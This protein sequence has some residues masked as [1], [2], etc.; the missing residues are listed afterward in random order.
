[1][2]ILYQNKKNYNTLTVPCE[3]SKTVSFASSQIKYVVVCSPPF[4]FEV[5][6]IYCIAFGSAS[7]TCCLPKSIAIIL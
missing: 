7:S 3:K 6:L 4:R 2:L 1:M 5:K